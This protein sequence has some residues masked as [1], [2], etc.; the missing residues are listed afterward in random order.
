MEYRRKNGKCKT[1]E[2]TPGKNRKSKAKVRTA[3]LPRKA[4]FMKM[5]DAKPGI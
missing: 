4:N 2:N 5:E 3:R 1:C